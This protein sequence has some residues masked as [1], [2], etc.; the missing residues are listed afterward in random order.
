MNI[1]C[2]KCEQDCTSCLCEKVE[3][4]N[5][6][7]RSKNLLIKNGII[8]LWQLESLKHRDILEMK[9]LGRGTDR[10]IQNLMIQCGF[11]FKNQ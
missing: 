9:G 11:K 3:D 6:S 4:S 10:E 5:L 2:N 1:Q 7:V 8:N